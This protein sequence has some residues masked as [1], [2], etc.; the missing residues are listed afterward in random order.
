MS[1]KTGPSVAFFQHG[2]ILLVFT[3]PCSLSFLYYDGGLYSVNYLSYSSLHYAEIS[4]FCGASTS[5]FDI[6][7]I[8]ISFCNSY[9]Q[10]IIQG[11]EARGTPLAQRLTAWNNFEDESRP[12]GNLVKNPLEY[13]H[14]LQETHRKVYCN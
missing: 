11:F 10:I 4:R 13:Y 12:S 3:R 1:S 5:K 6:I 2:H 8:F 9:I 14:H 7:I